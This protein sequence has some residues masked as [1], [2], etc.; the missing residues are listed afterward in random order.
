MTQYRAFVNKVQKH[1]VQENADIP[2]L[3]ETCSL[4][5]KLVAGNFK[6]VTIKSRSQCPSRNQ[7]YTMASG[8]SFGV[9]VAMTK[10]MLSR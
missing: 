9:F 8:H 6:L 10:L 7:Q 5:N 2:S 1:S 4:F 3:T